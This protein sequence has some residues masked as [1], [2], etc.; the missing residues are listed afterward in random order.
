MPYN[1][2]LAARVRKALEGRDGLAEK[3]M[4]GGMAFVVNGNMC[5]GVVKDG[6]VPSRGVGVSP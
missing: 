2:E 5:C 4:F 3:K 1:D 6:H